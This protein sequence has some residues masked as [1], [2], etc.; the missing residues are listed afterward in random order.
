MRNGDLPESSRSYRNEFMP[1]L[2]AAVALSLLHS[3]AE[4]IAARRAR[5]R[6]YCDLL[7]DREN[8]ELIAHGP[9][10][11]CLTQGIR[12]SPTRGGEDLALAVTQALGAAGYEVGGSYVPIHRL[13]EGATC[14]WDDLRRTDRIWPDLVELPCEPDVR[15]DD[16]E[17]ITTIV[18]TAAKL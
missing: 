13:H 3:L 6:V 5:V 12:V 8:L 4:N 14:V 17:R 18:K 1:N 7:G 2:N 16:V 11:A 10:S 9:G 15:L